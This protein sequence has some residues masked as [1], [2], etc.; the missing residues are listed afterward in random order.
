MVGQAREQAAALKC[1]N[2]NTQ[3]FPEDMAVNPPRV[4]EPKIGGNWKL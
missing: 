3:C 2:F 4:G 1:L